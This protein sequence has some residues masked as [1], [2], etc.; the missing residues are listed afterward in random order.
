MQYS[1]LSFF[2]SG[3]AN[4]SCTWMLVHGPARLVHA[5]LFAIASKHEDGNAT[6]QFLP[7]S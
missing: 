6:W 1:L 3:S 7:G 5:D 4:T 2:K